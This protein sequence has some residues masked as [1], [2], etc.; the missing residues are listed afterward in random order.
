MGGQPAPAPAAARV[1]RIVLPLAAN[2]KWLSIKKSG[3]RLIRSC[4][5]CFRKDWDAISEF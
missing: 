3:V 1:A 4:R 2:E 5:S